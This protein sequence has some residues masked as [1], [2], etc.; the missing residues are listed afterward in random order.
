MRAILWD[1]L[2][3]Q[4]PEK[5]MAK[6][7]IIIHPSCIETDLESSGLRPEERIRAEEALNHILEVI[8]KSSKLLG[9]NNLAQRI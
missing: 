2:V 6:I 1:Q 5:S 4:Q 7:E 8:G 3:L 9:F